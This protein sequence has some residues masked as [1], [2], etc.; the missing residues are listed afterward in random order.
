MRLDPAGTQ[1]QSELS[2]RS[3]TPSQIVQPTKIP[4]ARVQNS[5]FAKERWVCCEPAHHLF[6]SLSLHPW[7]GLAAS[8]VPKQ[9]HPIDIR[10]RATPDRIQPGGPAIV[11][12]PRQLP[13]LQILR[14]A[15]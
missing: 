14:A 12:L 7:N 3:P 13:A 11:H 2:L 9:L 5:F 8:V 1:K 6:V 4:N 15:R 10:H